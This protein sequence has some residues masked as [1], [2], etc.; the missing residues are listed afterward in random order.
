MSKLVP[1][2]TSEIIDE[3]YEYTD[4]RAA[5]YALIGRVT[6]FEHQVFEDL[7]E[8]ITGG[9][10]GSGAMAVITHEGATKRV[11]ATYYPERFPVPM[12]AL[13]ISNVDKGDRL[14]SFALFANE[15]NGFVPIGFETEQVS[16]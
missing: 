4:R 16:A 5:A 1:I 7:E 15:G 9:N 12:V 13:A 6:E 2:N 14:E 3:F 10:D 11:S 8:Q